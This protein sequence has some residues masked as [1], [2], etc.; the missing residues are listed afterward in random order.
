MEDSPTQAEQLR[1][2]FEDEDFVVSV[3][4]NGKEAFTMMRRDKPAIVVSDVVM[5][6]MDGCEL[7]RQIRADANL[8][9]I[10]VILLT[11]LSDPA[12]VIRS[13]EY[14]ADNFITKPYNKGLL[15]SRIHY[16]LTNMELRKGTKGGDG[17]GI[18]VSW[19]G[20]ELLYYREKY[21]DPRP[22]SRYL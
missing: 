9:D 10:P 16:I 4:N 5:P 21:A 17:E 19:G 7:C 13:M 11:L 20:E 3:A 6:E 12:D 14:G 18:S 1:H 8:K 2:I 22:S 15:L